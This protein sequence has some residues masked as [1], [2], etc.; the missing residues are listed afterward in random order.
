MQLTPA[1]P[2]PC[3]IEVFNR[4]IPGVVKLSYWVSATKITPDSPNPDPLSI[5]AWDQPFF[6]HAKVEFEGAVRHHLCG[7]ICLDLDIDTC[8]PAPDYEFP[9]VLIDLDPCGTGVYVGTIEIKPN[10]L[11]PKDDGGKCGRM[12]RLCLTIGSRD[13]C[14]NPGLIWGHC[15]EVSIVV[16]PPVPHN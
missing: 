15:D 9:E 7:K 1:T 8:G 12:Y 14:G 4:S 16:H 5:I 3:L 6:V 13:A 10:T 2:T 11:K